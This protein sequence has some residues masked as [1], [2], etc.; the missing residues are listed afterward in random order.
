MAEIEEMD[1]EAGMRELKE[2]EKQCYIE[3]G[4][5]VLNVRVHYDI[6]LS[7]CDTKAKVLHWVMHL[8]GKNWATLPLLRRFAELA[9]SYHGMDAWDNEI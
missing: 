1:F 4:Y 9:C 5:I 7:R 6:E 8:G 3:D 2:L